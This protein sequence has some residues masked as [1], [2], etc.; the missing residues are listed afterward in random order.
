MKE[1]VDIESLRKMA[2]YDYIRDLT[3]FIEKEYKTK[4]QELVEFAR[5]EG[6]EEHIREE[7]YGNSD[8][9]FF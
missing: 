9:T 7:K 2:S 3:G 4:S 6:W 8:E 5:E 1:K